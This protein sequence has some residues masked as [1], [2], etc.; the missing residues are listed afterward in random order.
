M[1][2]KHK[3]ECFFA[4]AAKKILQQALQDLYKITPQG[5]NLLNLA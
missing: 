5:Y 4:T 3:S 2:I 1:L